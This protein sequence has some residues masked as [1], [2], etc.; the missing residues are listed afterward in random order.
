MSYVKYNINMFFKLWF[1]GEL[2]G[3]FCVLMIIFST[4][5]LM[6]MSKLIQNYCTLKEKRV[7]STFTD[8]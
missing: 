4:E 3:F 5:C 8:C 6:Y 7:F 2:K 1:R